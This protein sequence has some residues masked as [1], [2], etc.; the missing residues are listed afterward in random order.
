MCKYCED[1]KKHY[2]D[3]KVE[4]GA[5]LCDGAYEDCCIVKD[6]DDGSY[7]IG[8]YGTYET[9]SDEIHFCPFCG[10]KLK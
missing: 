8:V 6:V 5:Y 9:F 1:L 7:Y 4:R 3:E 2:G 10:R